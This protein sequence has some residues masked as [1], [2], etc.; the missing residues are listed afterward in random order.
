MISTFN[1]AAYLGGAIESALGQTFGDLELIVV[2]DG[3]TDETEELLEQA[4]SDPRLRFVRQP[5]QGLSAARNRGLS[6]AQGE[7]LA[8]LDSDDRYTPTALEAHLAVFARRPGLGMTVGGYEYVDG[9]GR[10]LGRRSPW[11]EGGALALQDWLFNCYA[12]PGSV[13]LRREWLERVGEF[14]AS[15]HGSNDW[16]LFLRLAQAAVPWTGRR[17]SCANIAATPTT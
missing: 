2:D 7:Y 16:D 14:D 11:Q 4:R 5:N 1:R 15:T 6:L 12:M 9:S 10:A 3:S 8:F 13:L 17:P